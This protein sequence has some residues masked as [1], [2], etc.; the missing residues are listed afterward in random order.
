MRTLPSVPRPLIFLLVLGSAAL[1]SSK[2]QAGIYNVQSIVSSEAKAGVSGAIS[3]SADW[4]TGNIDFLSLSATPLARYRSGDHLVIGLAQANYKTSKSDTIISRTFEHL[5][6]RNQFSDRVLVEIY[7]Q[8][9]F[10]GVKR[11]KLRALAG[12]G[13][14][15]EIL[16]DK[17]FGLDIGVS[18]MLEYEELQD[19]GPADGGATDLQHRSSAY[20]VGRYELDE[21]VQFFETMYVQPRLTGASDYRVL[22]DTQISFSITKRLSFSTA[23]SISYDSTP[24][25]EIKKLDTALKSSLSYEI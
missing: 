22:N 2:A 21:R 16:R 10:D 7:G 25:L 11:L 5:R 17:S 19:D 24:P 8:H 13:P 4:R 14:K 12:A 6:Y 9:E 3:G 23:L 1:A 15:V 18:Y 20:I